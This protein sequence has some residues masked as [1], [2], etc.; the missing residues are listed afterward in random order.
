M[1]PSDQHKPA[2]SADTGQPVAKRRIRD[3]YPMIAR[4]PAFWLLVVT[5]VLINLPQ[6]LA[7]AQFGLLMLENGI[8]SNQIGLMVAA[9]SGGTLA[10]GLL[11]GIALDHLPAHW[12]A[13][14]SMLLPAIGLFLLSTDMNS[15]HLVL[16]AVLLFGLAYGAE[17]DIVAFLG[18]ADLWRERL[19]QA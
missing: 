15:L 14:C 10:G 11:C 9:L 6:T 5:M 16:T 8:S 1:I 18:R 12:V 17:G 13:T 3:D 7:I 19:Q 4:Q 2:V